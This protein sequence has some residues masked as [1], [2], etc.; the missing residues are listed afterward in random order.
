MWN[1]ARDRLYLHVGYD[2]PWVVPKPKPMV[3]AVVGGGLLRLSFQSDLLLIRAFQK[4]NH[5][6]YGAYDICNSM[7]V[8]SQSVSWASCWKSERLWVAG[9]GI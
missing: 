2:H 8:L 1:R 5:G 7:K 6:R 4:S 9:S 3:G